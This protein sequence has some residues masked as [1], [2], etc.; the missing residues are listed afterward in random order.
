MGQVRERWI[1]PFRDE[2]SWSQ[3]G[4]VKVKPQFVKLQVGDTRMQG[5]GTWSV[6]HQAFLNPCA[7][8]AHCQP[9]LH[10]F[11]PL[12]F[13]LSVTTKQSL[14]QSSLKY[15][16]KFWKWADAT[17]SVCTT[18]HGGHLV[19]LAQSLA[20]FSHCWCPVALWLP[21]MELPQCRGVWAN[22]ELLCNSNSALKERKINHKVVCPVVSSYWGTWAV[23]SPYVTEWDFK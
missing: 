13:L 16:L 21:V 10:I 20:F 8:G 19:E 12:V 3:K 23:G 11:P 2:D 17:T 18:G 14:Q 4:E 15:S 5:C 7:T 1:A 6:E 22:E 9:G